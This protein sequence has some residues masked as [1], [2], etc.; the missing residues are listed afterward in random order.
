M[1]AINNPLIRAGQHLVGAVR[2]ASE[3]SL[4]TLFAGDEKTLEQRWACS[5]VQTKDGKWL[6][7]LGEG[8]VQGGES[9]RIRV[10]DSGVFGRGNLRDRA[11]FEANAEQILLGALFIKD[12]GGAASVLQDGV[13]SSKQL[14]I[15]IVE[16]TT[17]PA[18][19]RWRTEVSVEAAQGEEVAL[20]SLDEALRKA[21]PASLPADQVKALMVPEPFDES[22][23]IV[24][25][26]SDTAQ[27]LTQSLADIG[28]EMID[29]VRGDVLAAS[30]AGALCHAAGATG[31]GV[32]ATRHLQRPLEGAATRAKIVELLVQDVAALGDDWDRFAGLAVRAISQTSATV[33]ASW[34]MGTA[35]SVGFASAVRQMRQAARAS[36]ETSAPLA[37]RATSPPPPVRG[38]G[39]ADDFDAG[40][41]A[42][43]GDSMEDSPEPAGASGRARG[44]P[45]PL[46]GAGVMVRAPSAGFDAAFP[47]PDVDEGGEAAGT[48]AAVPVIPVRPPPMMPPDQR[49]R[50]SAAA[51]IGATRAL[52]AEAQ[53]APRSALAFFAP[54]GAGNAPA[55]VILASLAKG[56]QALSL[57]PSV[58]EDAE[59]LGRLGAVRDMLAEVNGGRKNYTAVL[60]HH[61]ADAA[62]QTERD[63]AQLLEEAMRDGYTPRRP[64]GWDGAAAAASE[65][66]AYVHG[67]RGDSSRSGSFTS[68]DI[69]RH[70]TSLG[71]APAT[72]SEG[73]Q[74]KRDGAVAPQVVEKLGMD[75]RVLAE[76]K[77]ERAGQRDGTAD[78]LGVAKTMVLAH[79]QAMGA[80]LM[81]NLSAQAEL[82]GPGIVGTGPTAYRNVHA[83]LKNSIRR[84]L[85]KFKMDDTKV[86]TEVE[87]LASAIQ[88]GALD[89]ARLQIAVRL[90]GGKPRQRRWTASDTNTARGSWG[91]P[92]VLDDWRRTM[93]HMARIM[94]QFYGGVLQMPTGVAAGDDLESAFGLADLVDG[95]PDHRDLT[96][97]RAVETFELIF[98]GFSTDCE[99]YR[100]ELGVALP[101][102]AAHTAHVYT[103]VVGDM[104]Q[105]ELNFQQVKADSA[106]MRDELR[107][108][109]K[110]EVRQ[111]VE[112]ILSA[113]G[114]KRN[115]AGKP[116]GLTGAATKPRYRRRPNLRRARRSHPGRARAARRSNGRRRRRPSWRASRCRRG[117]AAARA[118]A[119]QRRRRPR[120][121]RR[122]RPTVPSSSP[123]ARASSSSRPS[124]RSTTT[125]PWRGRGARPSTRA[126]PRRRRSRA[127]GRRA[128]ASASR[129]ARR[130]TAT[131]TRPRRTSSRRRSNRTRRRARRSASPPRGSRQRRRWSPLPRKR[132]GRLQG[133]RR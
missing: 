121:A 45:A 80:L 124:G 61:T 19:A 43:G 126:A 82:R 108:E 128:S 69:K 41:G 57:S 4:A 63:V 38:G 39:A 115:A 65:L 51:L 120:P 10:H 47:P 93:R 13:D 24:L 91:S 31:W 21:Q 37:L 28:L 81:S 9:V 23:K 52:R 103:T 84:V 86:K 131:T 114:I 16:L 87:S 30:M 64:A 74:R 90:L 71:V 132:R 46:E 88:M 53:A 27:E 104:E 119:L 62:I 50:A 111:D 123:P 55:R 106:A 78:P 122:A 85:G 26:T 7:V 66:T 2:E 125:W 70:C 129:R 56:V 109:V 94:A 29:V 130:A 77:A 101:D 113:A 14:R 20:L 68:A 33:I 3:H 1:S 105:A 98:A 116:L 95:G 72:D 75:S 58:E 110:L 5:A 6:V 100:S 36:A 133:R 48:R 112:D 118:A 22:T 59:A 49:R 83:W 89:K 34:P 96:L 67:S 18:D 79:G 127:G 40:E 99:D 73:A 35:T 60:P 54:A 8:H 15:K 12:K 107:Q 44:G 117:R 11:W 76:V 17:A 42:G 97:E 25:G 102:L 32:E 92:D